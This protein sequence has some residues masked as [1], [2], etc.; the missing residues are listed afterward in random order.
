ML[1]I[2]ENEFDEYNPNH[3]QAQQVA[4]NDIRVRARQ[5]EE[6]RAQASYQQQAQA[7][8]QQQQA[9]RQQNLQS[10]VT[11]FQ[12]NSNWQDIDKNFYP[13]WRGNLD[14]TTGA[15]VDG[16]LAEGNKDKVRSLLTQVVKA[17]DA[18]KAPV[19]APVKAPPA[20]MGSEVSTDVVE[21]KGMADASKLAGMTPEERAAWF[22]TNKLV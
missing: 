7:Y 13:K 5:I 18:Q 2:A 6:E 15:V 11:E 10:I 12:A 8:M 4:M 21:S 22:I 9:I 14:A 20:V 1:G 3:Q 16:I 17:Y 19:K